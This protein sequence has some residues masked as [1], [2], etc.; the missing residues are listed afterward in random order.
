MEC[1]F[2]SWFISLPACPSSSALASLFVVKRR[3][4]DGRAFFCLRSLNLY[5]RQTSAQAFCTQSI[6]CCVFLLILFY[7][8]ESC[9]RRLTPCSNI[10][11][12]E[13]SVPMTEFGC[14]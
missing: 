1:V 2:W 3:K 5:L 14:S 13:D 11:K 12:N 10:P 9:T 6:F 4:L 7:S 8:P